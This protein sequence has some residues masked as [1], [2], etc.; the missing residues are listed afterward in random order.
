[1]PEACGLPD[2]LV[3]VDL[4]TTGG[5]AAHH[6]I[7]EVGI[8]RMRE[9]AALEEWSTLVNPECPIPAYIESFTGITNEMVAS[10]PRFGEIAGVVLEKLGGRA[11]RP[12]PVFVAHNARFDYGVLR[13][14][15]RRLSI[16]FSARVL[17]T[18]KL[19]RRLFP[20]HVR[21]SLDA[22]MERHD[23]ACA[24][25]HRALGDARVVRD[26]WAQLRV[27][28]SGERLGAVVESLLAPVKLPAQLPA[29]LAEELPEGPGVYRFFGDDDAL[30]YVGRSGS[31]RAG[32]LSHLAADR[33]GGRARKLRE[34]VQ[35][36]DWEETA[37]DLGA[38]LRELDCLRARAP[39]YNRHAASETGSVT[40]RVTEGSGAVQAQPVA[41]VPSEEI[42]ACYGVFNSM[43]DARK[44]LADIAA[45]RK[46]CPKIL[47]LEERPGS[48]LGYPLGHC[49][50]ACVGKEP[51]TL[52]AV[53]VQMALASL[54]LKPWP[55]L[56]RV[57]LRERRAFHEAEL[58][59]ID[60]W[61][62]LGTAR[63]EDELAA[64]AARRSPGHFDV[65]VYR[66]LVRY[67]ANHPK[68]DWHDLEAHS[69]RDDG[70][71]RAADVSRT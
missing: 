12:A 31:L 58:H 22:V 42:E 26:F 33:G 28:L 59:V 57:A 2:E 30:L 38:Q 8:V 21:H 5:N 71:Y 37:G 63:S 35:R 64:L 32:I 56:G 34:A 67:L 54:K 16:P 39:L 23:L 62:Y 41:D 50:G 29:G 9:G 61:R 19:S 70:A 55:F 24:A 3:F 45:A 4:E 46:L 25:R 15:F 13:A 44:A 43:K 65:Q 11:G 52:H 40:L 14:E 10:A 27:E 20:E 6:R 66:I 49:K 17:C 68:L 7:T 1:V 51:L 69:L 60:R 53:R 18:V 36:V 47:G 48:C